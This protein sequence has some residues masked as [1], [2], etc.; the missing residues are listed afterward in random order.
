MIIQL[1]KI[2]LANKTYFK[3]IFF[4]GHKSKWRCLLYISIIIKTIQT[5][6]LLQ[7]LLP[8]TLYSLYDC[9]LINKRHVINVLAP[10]NNSHTLIYDAIIPFPKQQ[11]CYQFLSDMKCPKVKITELS[12]WKKWLCLLDYRY[13]LLHLGLIYYRVSQFGKVFITWI[14]F[15]VHVLE[16]VHYLWIFLTFLCDW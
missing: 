1:I 8:I 15:G 13:H 11:G 14:L 3:I 7:C 5:T 10:L 16:Y 9:H 4:L 6:W 2:C 12:M